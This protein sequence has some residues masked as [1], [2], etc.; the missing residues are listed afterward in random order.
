M[1]S[2]PAQEQGF[3]TLLHKRNFLLLWL[4]QLLSMT[5]LNASNYALIIVI[6]EVTRST[7]LVGLAIIFYSLPA[8]L[9]G[10]PAGVFVDRH[11]KRRVLRGPHKLTPSPATFPSDHQDHQRV[12]K[13]WLRTH[14]RGRRRHW[15]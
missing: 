5:I 4:A 13:R 8:V 2:A 12:R 15:T 10:G 6:Q 9:L 11:S 1:P 14:A 7:T 3:L